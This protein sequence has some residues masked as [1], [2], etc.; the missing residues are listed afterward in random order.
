MDFDSFGYR[1]SFVHTSPLIFQNQS[2]DLLVVATP[3]GEPSDLEAALG[4]FMNEFERQSE[5][6]DVT[7]PFPKL[8]CLSPQENLLFTSVQFLNDYIYSNHNRD[9][10]NL[11]CD[12]FCVYKQ[13]RSLYTSQI[14]WPLSV[15]HKDNCNRPLTAEYAFMPK[16]KTKAPYIPASLIGLESSVNVKVQH[17]D[18][19]ENSAILLLK[20][21]ESPESLMLLYPNSLD[22]IAKEFASQNTE[23]GFWLGKISL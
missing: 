8:T 3:Y 16:D 18:V 17:I 19:D 20:S 22:V 15:L 10:F 1:G 9:T 14:G 21:N 11:G 5:D 23:Q 12:F 13:G 2:E 7:C 4:E 6:F